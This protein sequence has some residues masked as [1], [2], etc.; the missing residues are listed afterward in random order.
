M[1]EHSIK[2]IFAGLIND[3]QKSVAIT[4]CPAV[5]DFRKHQE[6]IN[7]KHNVQNDLILSYYHD[8]VCY[9]AECREAARIAKE[10]A[11]EAKTAAT[12]AKK[13]LD[14]V[15]LSILIPSLAAMLG[16]Y[17]TQ[18]YVANPKQDKIIKELQNKIT[19]D[20][21]NQKET[22]VMMK[23]LYQKLNGE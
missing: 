8:A 7:E 15:W 3:Y 18:L 11:E 4:G 23:K 5:N 19:Q 1:D 2:N 10:V 17:C 9:T 13:A 16:F 21:D 14:R 22:I 12:G 20:A 6:K